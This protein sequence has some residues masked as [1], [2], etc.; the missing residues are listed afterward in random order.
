MS[1]LLSFFF[2]FNSTCLAK[3]WAFL[4]SDIFAGMK[5]DPNTLVKKLDLDSRSV[6]STKTGKQ[7]EVMSFG[8]LQW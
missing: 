4:T 5:I 6:V 3:D 2:F 8:G 7:C 1:G